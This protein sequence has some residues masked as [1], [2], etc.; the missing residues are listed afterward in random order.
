VRARGRY[1]SRRGDYESYARV[2]L[3]ELPFARYT[4]SL[5]NPRRIEHVGHLSTITSLI[6][7]RTP[8]QHELAA[9]TDVPRI[10]VLPA[11]R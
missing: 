4:V 8:Q 6:L 2:V 11:G 7:D 10:I 1:T 3:S 5:Q 9:L